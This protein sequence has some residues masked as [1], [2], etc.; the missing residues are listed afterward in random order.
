MHGPP[1]L[2]KN[3][4]TAS[5][6]LILHL[7][8]KKKKLTPIQKFP[9]WTARILLNPSSHCALQE[10]TP[11]IQL[12]KINYIHH[13]LSLYKVNIDR[14]RN[15]ETHKQT[16]IERKKKKWSSLILPSSSSSSFCFCSLQFLP[17]R[18]LSMFLLSPLT[19]AIPIF[20]EM[21]T[22]SVHLMENQSVYCS[23]DTQVSVEISL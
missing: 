6:L 14:E 3:S 9:T 18:V 21:E 1:S 13:H 10:N 23:I 19:M 20:L 12:S 4:K 15:K 7:P 11:V 2:K 8:K 16:Q 5:P 22:W 17:S